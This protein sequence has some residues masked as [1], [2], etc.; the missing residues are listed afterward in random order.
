MTKRQWK[1]FEAD[2]KEELLKKQYDI[3]LFDISVFIFFIV[4]L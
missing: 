2:L 4:K 1:F 3:I